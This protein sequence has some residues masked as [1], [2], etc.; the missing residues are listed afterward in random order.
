MNKLILNGV[1]IEL[2]NKQIDKLRNELGKRSPY[3]IGDGEKY[4]IADE[5]GKINENYNDL[6]DVDDNLIKACNAVTDKKLAEEINK[7]QTIYRAL[8]KFQ[9]ENDNKIDWDNIT[10][11]RNIVY[12]YNGK[13]TRINSSTFHKDYGAVY[14]TTEEMAQRAIDE[15]LMPLL[16]GDAN[17]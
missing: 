5:F 3:D 15:V 14:F 7:Q 2:T 11:K 1:E 8:K 16:G 17:E 13:K 6:D 4:F 10:Y 12:D 9:I